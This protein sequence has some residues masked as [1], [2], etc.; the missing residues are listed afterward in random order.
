MKLDP[1]EIEVRAEELYAAFWTGREKHPPSLADTNRVAQESWRQ[2]ARKSFEYEKLS[3]KKL[4]CLVKVMSKEREEGAG[5]I[6]LIQSVKNLIVERDS[7]EDDLLDIERARKGLMLK[8]DG[9]LARRLQELEIEVVRL[10]TEAERYQ[11][12]MIKSKVTSKQLQDELNTAYKVIGELYLQNN[13]SF[14]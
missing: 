7:L 8:G 3:Q 1:D 14:K 6:G 4:K 9:I 2:S 5:V 12:L 10:E 13:S 11:K